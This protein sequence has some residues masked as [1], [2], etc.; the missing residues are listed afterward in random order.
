MRLHRSTL[1]GA[2]AL[3]FTAALPAQAEV[4][5]N[6][7]HYDNAGADTGEAIEVVGSAGES[8]AGYQLVLYNGSNGQSYR[9]DTLGEGNLATCG[10]QV[11]LGVVN[12]PQDGLQNGPEDGIALVDP[13]GGVVQFLSYEGTLTAVNGPAAGMTSTDIGVSQPNSTPVGLS[14]QLGGE[15]NVYADF[16]W[17]ESAAQTFGACNNNQSFGETGNA[18]PRVVETFPAEGSD[19]FP[20]AADMTITFSEPVVV[21]PGAFTLQCEG[22]GRHRGTALDHVAQ[23]ATFTVTPARPLLPTQA[24]TLRIDASLVAD[25]DGTAPEADTV[26]DFR[27]KSADRGTG[28]GEYYGLV[29]DSSPGQLRCS[30]HETIRGHVVYPYSGSGTSTWT[31]LEVA[32]EDPNDEG[33]IL[34]VYRNHSYDKV[35]D[36]SGIGS[37]PYRYNREHTWPNSLGFPSNTGNLGLPNAPYTDT[38][39]LYLSDEAYNS[40]RGNMP[41]ADCPSGCT[42]RPTEFNDGRGGG[43]GTYPGNSNWYEGPN[44]NQGSFEVW[45]ARKGD[46]A[47]AVMYMAIR[48]EG[49]VHPTTGQGEPDLELT[50]DRSRIV[51]SSSLDTPSY[52]GLLSTLIEWHLADPPDDAERA[53][54]EV[55]FA[56]QGNRNPFIDHPE[57]ATEAL[58]TSTTPATCELGTP[59]PQEPRNPRLPVPRQGVAPEAPAAKAPATSRALRPATLRR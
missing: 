35:N 32:D 17:A 29:N 14:L 15:G 18:A 23:A 33:K 34:D 3:A 8:L 20:Y 36:R 39:M 24:C 21:Q 53:R 4:F 7:I 10:G 47:R 16:T 28:S 38:H 27:V 48:Y 12:Y 19:N 56:Y 11:R 59:P 22:P 41:F 6:E 26:V 58:F 37:G 44:G 45:G 30:L 13:Q 42:E 31:I 2:I 9:T 49:G 46:M 43:S 54:N 5:I 51:A 55:V 50:N 25:L 57:W 40:N 52:M 1:C